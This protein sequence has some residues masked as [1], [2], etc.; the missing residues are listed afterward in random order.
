[1]WVKASLE[2]FA[3]YGINITTERQLNDGEYI[4]HLE[5]TDNPEFFLSVRFDANVKLLTNDELEEII[6]SEETQE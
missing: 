4:K 2:K 5:L 6:K 3:E 1:M